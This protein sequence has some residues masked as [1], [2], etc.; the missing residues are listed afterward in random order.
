MTYQEQ[1]QDERWRK[2]RYEILCRDKHACI[3]C[4]YVGDRVNV[5]H[6]KYTGMA[7]EAPDKD[8]ITLCWECHR[9]HHRPDIVDKKYDEMRVGYKLKDILGDG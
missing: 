1:L 7:W 3:M 4:G 2:R 9:K 8:L 6:L 5:H